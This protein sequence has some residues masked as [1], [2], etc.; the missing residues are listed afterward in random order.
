MQIQS[1]FF[2]C[3][4][5]PTTINI[6]I[7]H[8]EFPPIAEIQGK[9][10]TTHADKGIKA[11]TLKSRNIQRNRPKLQYIRNGS[12]QM[13]K[14]LRGVVIREPSS[15][16]IPSQ[17]SPREVTSNKGGEGK[18]KVVSEP[19]KKA[20]EPEA[21]HFYLNKDESERLLQEL[22]EPLFKSLLF[23]PTPSHVQKP[24]TNG[25]SSASERNSQTRKDLPG[26]VIR[27][28]SSQVI[29]PRASQH[30]ATSKNVGKGK[31]KVIFN[32]E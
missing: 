15:Q 27:E 17:A 6:H 22:R 32:I 10:K 16:V 30:E 11:D 13:R 9:S 5:I 25:T 2:S 31:E 24:P 7:H 12:F 3:N 20:F 8:G 18:E 21:E 19:K 28:P 23:M 1:E 4:R 29:L 26:V 14:G